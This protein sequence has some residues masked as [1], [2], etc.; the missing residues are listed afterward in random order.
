MKHPRCF[1]LV[2]LCLLLAGCVT[3][4]DWQRLKKDN[5]DLAARFAHNQQEGWTKA[6]REAFRKRVDQNAKEIE[7]VKPADWQKIG[8]FVSQI[9]ALLF[10]GEKAPAVLG[11]FRRM[12]GRKADPE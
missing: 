8:L 7:D 2:G 5:E 10:L 1:L 9:V 6:E 3:T 12:K 4:A 11:M